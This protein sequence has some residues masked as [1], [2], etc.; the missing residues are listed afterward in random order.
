M[1][2]SQELRILRKTVDMLLTGIP[3]DQAIFDVRFTDQRSLASKI[4]IRATEIALK[5]ATTLED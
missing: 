3:G 1:N 4:V 5:E 2:E